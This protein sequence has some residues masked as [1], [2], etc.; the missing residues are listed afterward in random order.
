MALA[1]SIM[2]SLFDFGSQYRIL[3]D[4]A[5]ISAA[6]LVNTPPC[7]FRR[8]FAIDTAKSSYGVFNVLLH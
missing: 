7:I 6:S 1:F 3:L 5:T 2:A 8:V 4:A